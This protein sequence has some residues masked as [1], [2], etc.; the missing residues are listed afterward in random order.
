MRDARSSCEAKERFGT[1][2]MAQKVGRKRRR[3]EKNCSTYRC[4]FC[5]GY[6]LG[7]DLQ[8]RR[9]RHQVPQEIEA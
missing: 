1:W 9:R 8:R 6:H 5:H 2:A 4:I 3:A 7:E